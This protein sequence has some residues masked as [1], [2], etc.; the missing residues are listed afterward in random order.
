MHV[1]VFHQCKLFDRKKER[2][3]RDCRLAE[4][5]SYSTQLPYLAIARFDC[6]L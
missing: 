6:L 4:P 2:E 3:R 1:S 5:A